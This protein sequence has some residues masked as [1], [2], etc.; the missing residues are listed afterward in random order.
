MNL[1]DVL[2]YAPVAVETVNE[3]SNMVVKFQL[4]LVIKADSPEDKVPVIADEC[5]LEM[6]F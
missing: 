4:L 6:E 3:D 1:L 5:S 2:E